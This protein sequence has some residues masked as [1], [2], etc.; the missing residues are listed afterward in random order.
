[1]NKEEI[2][3]ENVVNY[4]QELLEMSTDKLRYHE[5]AK[6]LRRFTATTPTDA[7][8]LPPSMEWKARS[9]GEKS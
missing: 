7:F 9:P 6:N 3:P 1:M 4:L 8:T 2:T 5:V